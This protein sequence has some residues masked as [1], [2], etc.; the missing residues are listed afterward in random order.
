MPNT[1]QPARRTRRIGAAVA[2]AAL[3]GVGLPA[4]AAAQDSPE[5]SSSLA[6]F[7]PEEIVIGTDLTAGSDALRDLGSGGS[8]DAGL[9]AAQVVGS[10]APLEALG[11]AGGSAAASV[12]SSG[13]LPGSTYVN[14]TGSIGSGVIGLGS[15]TLPEYMIGSIALQLTGAYFNVMAARQEAGELTENDMIFWHNVVLGSAEGAGLLEDAA[16]ATGTEIPGS[17]AASIESVRRAAA[18]DPLAAL[19]DADP[20][21][22]E[23]AAE[24]AA[25]GAG[26]GGTAGVP[27]ATG[28][29]AGAKAG[30]K[31]APTLA[32]AAGP[33]VGAGPAAATSGAP[34]LAHTGTESGAIVGLA[35]AAVLLGSLLV[36]A[37]RR[38]A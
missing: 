3:A 10:V 30:A 26:D 12:A 32:A 33:A 2:A 21:T 4:V 7:I 34:A 16:A 31:A 5:E 35:G 38:R 18:E 17:L 36:F 1:R 22:E 13:S 8:V 19:D 24:A 14:A 28:A 20:V 11:S 37:S 9:S 15:V 6:G 23:E 27:V 25:A 29:G